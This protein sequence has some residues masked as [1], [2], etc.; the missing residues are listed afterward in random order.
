MSRVRTILELPRSGSTGIH[1]TREKARCQ[2]LKYR[3][4]TRCQERWK[5]SVGSPVPIPTPK[6]YGVLPKTASSSLP[7]S[8]SA[9]VCDE[10]LIAPIPQPCFPNLNLLIEQLKMSVR[11]SNRLSIPV[12]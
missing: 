8:P 6:P 2:P 1:C 10:S 7:T 4:W 9:S 11:I 12:M 3:R 5:H